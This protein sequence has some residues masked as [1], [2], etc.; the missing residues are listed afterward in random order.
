[1]LPTNQEKFSKLYMEYYGVLLRFCKRQLDDLPELRMDAE[2]LV[3]ETLLTAAIHFDQLQEHENIG[4]WLMKTCYYRIGNAKKSCFVRRKHMAVH[5]DAPDAPEIGDMRDRLGEWLN[6]CESNEILE[7]L[8]H[9][10]TEAEDDVFDDYF[11]ENRKIREIA[12]NRKISIGAVKSALH[13][14]RQKAKKIISK[15]M[16]II[17]LFLVSFGT[18]RNCIK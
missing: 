7:E 16:I 3:Q 2:D 10:L 12:E 17:F 18:H 6:Q 5:L 4:G 9:V 15:N 13:R 11:M 8:Y 1:M 14:I